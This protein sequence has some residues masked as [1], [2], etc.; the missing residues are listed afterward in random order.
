MRG[1][2]SNE[3]GQHMKDFFFPTGRVGLGK[4]EM[5]SLTTRSG[6]KK[7]KTNNIASQSGPTKQRLSFETG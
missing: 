7:R 1:N 3:P 6:Y 4:R 2:F 5:S